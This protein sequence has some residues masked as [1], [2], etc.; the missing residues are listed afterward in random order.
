MSSSPEPSTATV[1][2]S[3]SRA[4]QWAQ[5]SMPRARPLTTTSP[6]DARSAARRRATARPYARRPPGPD[7]RNRRPGRALP[8]SPK[9][10]GRAAGRRSP[11]GAAGTRRPRRSRYYR[12]FFPV[13]QVPPAPRRAPRVAASFRAMSARIP[14]AAR[15]PSP[16]PKTSS[17]S[18]NAFRTIRAAR[19]HS[20]TA[21]FR[22]IQG[23]RRSS[24]SAH[25]SVQAPG[26][27]K[28]G[29]SDR[30]MTRSVL[31]PRKKRPSFEW[32]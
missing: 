29:T 25:S 3:D 11:G 24:T 23:T 30:E 12:P 6:R 16:A 31:L 4:P 7:D 32:V 18:G 1:R 5:E 19:G 27:A 28:T 14:S 15:A 21:A 17:T 13:S 22:A 8:P 10:T 9:R 26:M 20:Q 2:P